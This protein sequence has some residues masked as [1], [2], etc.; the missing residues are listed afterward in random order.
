LKDNVS[1]KKSLLKLKEI[2]P[3]R[4][5]EMEGSNTGNHEMEGRKRLCMQHGM[6]WDCITLFSFHF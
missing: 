1:K 6:V 5:F 2:L 4:S 3:T